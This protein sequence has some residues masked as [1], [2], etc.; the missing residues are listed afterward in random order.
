VLQSRTGDLAALPR[1]WLVGWHLLSPA[2]DGH[3]TVAIVRE[4]EEKYVDVYRQATAPLAHAGCLHMQGLALQAVRVLRLMHRD[5]SPAEGDALPEITARPR[6]LLAL[7]AE[8]LRANEERPPE[9][10]RPSHREDGWPIAEPGTGYARLLEEI[11]ARAEDTG[12]INLSPELLDR[13]AAPAAQRLDW[14]MDCML[15][16]L[17][18]GS[19]PVAVLDHLAP[20]GTLDARFATALGH[21]HG[22]VGQVRAYRE[23]LRCLEQQVGVD[24]VEVL[25]PP[26]SD[27]AANAV[28]R[29]S[30]T[31]AWTGDTDRN[32]YV[33]PEE[34]PR[35]SGG[36]AP[37][38][39]ATR[40]GGPPARYI[41]LDAITLRRRGG[42]VIA[43]VGGRRIW[44]VHHAT[45][46]PMPP[47]NLVYR[48]LMAAA[49]SPPLWGRSLGFSLDALGERNAMPRITIAG[50]L[51]LS[52]AQWRVTREQLW[53]E[54]DTPLAKARALRRLR[55]RLG[56]PR[57][58]FVASHRGGKPLLGDL[59]SLRAIP[60]LER[61]AA[62][63]SEAGL[64]VE[65]MLPAPDQLAVTDHACLPG[66]RLASE[67]MLR[68]PCDESPA[69]MA[70]RLA[71][72]LTGRLRDQSL[73]DTLVE[74]GESHA[75]HEHTDVDRP[76][77]GAATR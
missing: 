60:L 73:P 52:C 24:C 33:P 37:D 36:S 25:I 67:L 58:V 76:D 21:L 65:E 51:V 7:V 48:F 30:Y 72:A 38:P 59:E 31:R 53:D 14:P 69:A 19:G 61:A 47:W 56:L 28:R 43:E 13:I 17:R 1:A 49:P 15:R 63:A 12:G 8:R 66:D 3:T 45:R 11:A 9:P 5:A 64:V 22:D 35:D 77:L 16:M 32:T 20:A 42:D 70:M 4:G 34:G 41:P 27:R 18:P 54:G 23:F 40:G 68:L 50:E 71:P 74:G 75:D 2:S 57:W 55:Q 44:P 46:S 10:E 62:E 39:D 29:P 6:S 26:L